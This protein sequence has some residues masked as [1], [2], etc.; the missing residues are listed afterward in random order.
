MRRI[1]LCFTYLC[2]EIGNIYN[3]M[4]IQQFQQSICSSERVS[5]AYSQGII[6]FKLDGNCNTHSHHSNVFIQVN[7]NE[8][9]QGNSTFKVH[10][11]VDRK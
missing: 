4:C 9:A 2:I 10:L 6:V 5:S 8:C 1:T 11:Q 3:L 7:R